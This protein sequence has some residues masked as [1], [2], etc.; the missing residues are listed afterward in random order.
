MRP[1]LLFAIL[2][3]PLFGLSQ[4]AVKDTVYG[5]V[6]TVREKLIFLDEHRQNFKLFSDE[7][8]YGHHGF[9]DR[10]AT[11]NR[12]NLFWNETRFV[13]YV[14]YYREYDTLNR[15]SKE[16][17]YYKDDSFLT[18]YEYKYDKENNLIEERETDDDGKPQ[19]LTKWG[20]NYQNQMTSEVSIFLNE[21]YFFF[22]AYAYDNEGNIKEEIFF[23]NNEKQAT[24]LHEYQDRKRVRTYR[25]VPYKWIKE[26]SGTTLTKID[27]DTI[28][29]YEY[30]YDK[31]GNKIEYRDYIS[32]VEGGNYPPRIT[33]FS[34]D[35]NNNL[36]GRYESGNI[37]FTA[38]FRY[39]TTNQLILGEN[40]VND[41]LSNK[42]EYYYKNNNLVKL[43]S[44]EDGKTNV[45]TF[46]YKFDKTGNW[47]EQ[48]KAINGEVLFVR[49]REIVYY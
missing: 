45:M 46:T 15:I 16:T 29:R 22:R 21:N 37:R 14:N 47:V 30:I 24:L 48:T 41:T 39:N 6:K 34:Y 12:F 4:R 36:T 9:T 3:I 20:Y 2:M 49:K 32:Q 7:G 40:L 10:K 11:L 35:K 5:N 38:K 18:C 19:Y 33:T 26:N 43:I 8:E 44:T 17:W 27:G 23:N 28:L 42:N 31:N 25:S 1:L 13:H